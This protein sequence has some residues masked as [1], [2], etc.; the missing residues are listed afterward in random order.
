MRVPLDY[1]P[2]DPGALVPEVGYRAFAES[3]AFLVPELP[4]LAR[5]Y[6]ET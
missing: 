5:L 1:L 2:S 6:G 4:I 3:D